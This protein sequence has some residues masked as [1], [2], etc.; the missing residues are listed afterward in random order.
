MTF[1]LKLASVLLAISFLSSCVMPDDQK[2]SKE[3]KN[4]LEEYVVTPLE[5]SKQGA[6][7]ADQ[8]TMEQQKQWD[9]VEYE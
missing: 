4:V 9:A 8:R 7:E 2:Y 1:I 5:R 3:E 6:K